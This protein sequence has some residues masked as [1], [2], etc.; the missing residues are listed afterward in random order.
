MRW[1]L[2]HQIWYAFHFEIRTTW[3]HLGNFPLPGC[4]RDTRFKFRLKA[5]AVR[6]AQWNGINTN[7]QTTPITCRIEEIRINITDLPLGLAA[8]TTIETGSFDIAAVTPA[9]TGPNSDHQQKDICVNAS[10]WNK[11]KLPKLIYL[12]C[13]PCKKTWTTY[14][15]SAWWRQWK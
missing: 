1:N 15:S 13:L 4:K 8:G 14:W 5:I 3:W 11:R 10:K 12:L 7:C 2:N 9:K 6:T